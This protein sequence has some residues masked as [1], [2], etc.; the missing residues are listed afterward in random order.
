VPTHP[1]TRGAVGS[2]FT[3]TSEGDPNAANNSAVTTTTVIDPRSGSYK[4][5]AANGN[6]YDLTIDFD[7]GSYTMAGAG[8]AQSFGA[9]SGSE[10]TVGGAVR[11]RVADDLIVGGHDFG[12]GVLPY[13][14]VRSFGTAVADATGTYTFVIRDVPTAGPATTRAA[15]AQVSGNQL[16]LCLQNPSDAPAP[17]ARCDPAKQTSYII[18]VSNGVYAA[19]DAGGTQAFRFFV[20]RSGASRIL[21]GADAT[22]DGRQMR[23]GLQ[24][25]PALLGG[26]LG[27]P[28]T[29]GAWIPTM[30]ISPTLYLVS[31]AG[32]GDDYTATLQAHASPETQ[33][34][35]RTG[36]LNNPGND[37]IW[38]MQSA[39]L[40]VAFGNVGAAG[41]A[42]GL[43][44]IVLPP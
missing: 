11:F 27:G 12:A 39:P 42:R 25:Q 6:V 7:A 30:T 22:V 17:G 29:S 9:P 15:V 44:Q 19:F 26:T 40:A 43:L 32:S 5:I 31:G 35:L 14:A 10:Y 36:L 21:I 16:T 33:E 4:A 34:S 18:A 1:G 24:S 41:T 8:N 3:V 37:R 23:I 2:T 13:V 38:V 20:A 28:S